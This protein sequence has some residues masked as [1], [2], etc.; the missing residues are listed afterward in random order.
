VNGMPLN[1]H[2]Q[3]NLLKDI[4]T[5]HQTDCCGSVSEC[6]QLERLV[7]S[8]MVNNNLDSN[9]KPILQE[10]YNYSQ[11]GKY[12]ADLDEHILSNQTNL[13][14]WVDDIGQFS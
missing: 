1:H 8:L 4:L 14:S 12:S 10:I 7:K 11:N 13:S 5:N 3:V 9:V 6:E 2:D